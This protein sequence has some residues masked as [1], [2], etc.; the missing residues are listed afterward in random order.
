GLPFFRFSDGLPTLG[1][2]G[3]SSRIVLSGAMFRVGLAF[4]RNVPV[5]GY[6]RR[7]LNQVK[8]A[9]SACSRRYSKI[10]MKKL[11]ASF[12]FL[13]TAGAIASTAI[14]TPAFKME[15]SGDW[16]QEQTLDSEQ[17][18]YYSKS[19]DTGLT[20]SY[21]LMNAKPSDTE[22]IASKLIEFRLQG[23][24][25]AAN[26]FNLKMTIAEPILVPFSKG[27]QVAYYGHDSNNR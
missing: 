14:D 5:A 18:S 24:N 19:L 17:K 21:L 12:I 16:V 2:L 27:H 22:R 25:A 8:H 1:Y 20:T 26:E 13:F 4:A 10:H 3:A 7:L 11:L 23:E 15:L 9:T 6:E